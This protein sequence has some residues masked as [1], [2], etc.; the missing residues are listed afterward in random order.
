MSVIVCI[1]VCNIQML[2]CEPIIQSVFETKCIGV[3]YS[4]LSYSLAIYT[5]T[6]VSKKNLLDF[7]FGTNISVATDLIQQT[8]ESEE[9]K[10][11][12]NK[13]TESNIKI[14]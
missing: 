8:T 3:S 9:N 1:Y 5:N 2:V 10:Y 6:S 12:K 7:F 14:E 4:N 13:T 11:N